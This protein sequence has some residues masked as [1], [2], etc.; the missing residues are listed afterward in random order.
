[1]SS[2]QRAMVY[3]RFMSDL[4]FVPSTLPTVKMIVV[5]FAG[6]LLRNYI[7]G[8]VLIVIG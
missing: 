4:S 3:A 7:D 8:T 1:M 2:G 6:D 5:V